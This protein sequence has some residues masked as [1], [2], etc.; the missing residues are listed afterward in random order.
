MSNALQELAATYGAP[1]IDLLQRDDVNEI[2]VNS[3]DQVIAEIKGEFVVQDHIW[4]CEE[5]L[6]NYVRMIAKSLDQQF[7]DRFPVLDAR[8]EDGTRINAVRPPVAV[9]G[10]SMSI[11]PYPKV[12]VDRQQYVEWGGASEEIFDYLNQ[13]I[14]EKKNI[15]VAGGTGSGKTT[16]LR[17]LI[18]MMPK[19][20][21]LI[22]VE[23]TTEHLVKDHSNFVC[24]EAAKRR[25]EESGLNVD[26]G[27]LIVNALRMRPDRIGVGEIRD[28]GAAQAFL[29]A[30][31]TG[32]DG[33]VTTIHSNGAA[34]VTPRILE[35]V[36]TEALNMDY[37]V[38]RIM[39]DIDVIVWIGK[40]YENGRQYKRVREVV[41]LDPVDDTPNTDYEVNTVFEFSVAK[42]DWQKPNHSEV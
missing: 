18:D 16:L 22:V 2:C 40:Q 17:I 1:L 34:S 35:L 23:D 24:L 41:T 13:A 21:R 29:T 27:F 39:R 28:P 7:D 10:I 37:I 8:L 32:H 14:L 42:G 19:N 11:R 30:L 5:D 26:M 38:R 12:V 25:E 4:E 9:G 36:A 3:Y 20:E 6:E 15:V 31:N 33:L